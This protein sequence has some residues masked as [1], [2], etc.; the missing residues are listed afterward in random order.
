MAVRLTASDLAQRVARITSLVTPLVSEPAKIH[1]HRFPSVKG[2]VLGVLPH[3]SLCVGDTALG[4]NNV[5]A[6][7]TKFR[8]SIDMIAAEILPRYQ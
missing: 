5:G 6:L 7:M 4:G 3:V 2:Y 1:V 8:K